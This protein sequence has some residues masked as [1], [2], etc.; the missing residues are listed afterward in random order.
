VFLSLRTQYRLTPDGIE[1]RHLL[2]RDFWFWHE[3]GAV[4]GV[5]IEPDG[6]LG[7]IASIRTWRGS[8]MPVSTRVLDREGRV[9]FRIGPWI[10]HRRELATL[11]RRKIHPGRTESGCGRIAR[12]T[13]PPGREAAQG[14]VPVCPGR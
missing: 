6:T 5:R 10:R 8:D 14:L 11:I 2:R 3:M 7:E 4:V 1:H 12:P 13:M 9:L